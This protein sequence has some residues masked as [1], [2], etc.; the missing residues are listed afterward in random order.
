[1]P[2]WQAKNTLIIPGKRTFPSDPNKGK[3]CPHCGEVI[4][5][6]VPIRDPKT[7]KVKM[8]CPA[9]GEKPQTP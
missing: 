2:K 1:M 4:L 8:V 6:L 7:G 5:K 3:K 9:C